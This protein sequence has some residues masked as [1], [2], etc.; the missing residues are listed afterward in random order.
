MFKIIGKLNNMINQSNKI[1][2]VVFDP[3]AV[4]WTKGLK[5]VIK[6]AKQFNV[7]VAVKSK[8]VYDRVMEMQPSHNIILIKG[9]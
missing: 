4:G 9:E 5:G 7:P 2:H 6:D 8:D 3:V 1:K